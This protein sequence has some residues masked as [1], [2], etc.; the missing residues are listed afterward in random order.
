MESSGLGISLGNPA[1]NLVPLRND[2]YGMRQFLY[3]SLTFDFLP[4]DFNHDGS[5]DVA[6]Y[7][8]WRDGLGNPFVASDYN[9]WRMHFGNVAVVSSPASSLASVPEPDSLAR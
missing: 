1:S 8:T 2:D 3:P 9:V 7:V 4:G 6:D 5:V